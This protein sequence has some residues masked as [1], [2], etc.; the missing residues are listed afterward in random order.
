MAPAGP[1]LVSSSNG[2][3][4][5]RR[6]LWQRA[7]RSAMTMPSLRQT[8]KDSALASKIMAKAVAIAAPHRPKSGI[9]T[10]LRPM[11]KASVMA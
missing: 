7:R 10:T 9:S 3:A 8:V 4:A 6:L 11:L 2:M 5:I 1:P